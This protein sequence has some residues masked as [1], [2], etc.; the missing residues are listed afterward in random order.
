MGDPQR[1]A[2]QNDDNRRDFLR[3]SSL[4]LASAFQPSTAHSKRPIR[5]GLLGCGR[6]GIKRATEALSSNVDIR[7]AGLADLQPAP[8]QKA[9]RSLKGRYG[10]QF[11]VSADSRFTGTTAY[12]QLLNSDL[13]AV[14]IG[15]PSLL[16]SS[17]LQRVVQAGKHAFVEQAIATNTAGLARVFAACD[18]ADKLGVSIGIGLGSH[19]CGRTGKLTDLLR[20]GLIGNPL[21]IVA[22]C[23]CESPPSQP[24]SC[25]RMVE[26]SI[27]ESP[28]TNPSSAAALY[29]QAFVD[30]Y[31]VV[32]QVVG[33]V[34]ISAVR[35]RTSTSGQFSAV[36][37]ER[38]LF[39]CS[40]GITLHLSGRPAHSR[41][42]QG[43]PAPGGSGYGKRQKRSPQSSIQR[44]EVHGTRGK[45]DWIHDRISLASEGGSR[46][47]QLDAAAPE[48]TSRLAHWLHCIDGGTPVN[49]GWCAADGMTRIWQATESE[50]TLVTSLASVRPT[51]GRS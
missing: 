18:L 14:I 11:E 25:D 40:D 30:V 33:S 39:Q 49:D 32:Q 41:P 42:A 46:W 5:I 21:R 34:P 28:S 16:R 24:G 27:S 2:V 3:G 17:H 47:R 15:T 50:P 36:W 29:S 31:Q 51:N 44:F 20:K 4:L 7:I 12:S 37:S 23:R 10:S 43:R 19:L 13:E 35:S 26:S 6:T 45:Y 38:F 1:S 48:A 9:V 22:D 8:L